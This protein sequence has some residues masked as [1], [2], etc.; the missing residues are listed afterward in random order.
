MEETEY[1]ILTRIM[2]EQLKKPR[3]FGDCSVKPDCYIEQEDDISDNSVQLL[4][5]GKELCVNSWCLL[6]G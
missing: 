5:N 2:I 1:M 3:L 6:H 4:Q